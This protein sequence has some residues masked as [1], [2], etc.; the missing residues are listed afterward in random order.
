MQ[1]PIGFFFWI[2]I[3]KYLSI[4]FAQV[5]YR[6]ISALHIAVRARGCILKVTSDIICSSLFFIFYFLIYIRADTHMLAMQNRYF[7]SSQLKKFNQRKCARE[8]IFIYLL[9]RYI[10][11]SWFFFLFFNITFIYF[12]GKRILQRGKS[13]SKV[14]K[15]FMNA[16][17]HIYTRT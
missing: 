4:P 1:Y 15:T 5:L 3:C 9:P 6:V 10:T 12:F 7:N 8:Q 14:N 13:H 2:L 17:K 11:S 16:F